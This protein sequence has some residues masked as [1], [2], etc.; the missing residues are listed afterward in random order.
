MNP[1]DNSRQQP[2]PLLRTGS[3][4][5]LCQ[6]FQSAIAC[7][8]FSVISS[9]IKFIYGYEH[10]FLSLLIRELR[11]LGNQYLDA[12]AHIEAGIPVFIYQTERD[13]GLQNPVFSPSETVFN[14]A[15]SLR[16]GF[17]RSR[18]H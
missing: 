13:G 15:E 12:S 7:L 4:L 9:F 10:W 14:F 16:V 5:V 2:T 3:T 17:R 1:P 18:T 6:N 11:L 8:S